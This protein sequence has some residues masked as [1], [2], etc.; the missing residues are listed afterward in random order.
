MRVRVVHEIE[1]RGPTA[2]AVLPRFTAVD[3]VMSG[4]H[5]IQSSEKQPSRR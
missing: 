3:D 4:L 5:E 2:Q 1:R